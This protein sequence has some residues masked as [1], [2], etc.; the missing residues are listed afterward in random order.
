MRRSVMLA[1][2]ILPY[3]LINLLQIAAMM[4]LAAAL[5]GVSLG[6]RR[7]PGA[8]GGRVRPP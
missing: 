2:K 8:H 7:L 1:G 5:F 6:R 3:Y 4:G